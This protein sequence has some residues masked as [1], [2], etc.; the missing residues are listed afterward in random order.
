MFLEES[1][2]SL[3]AGDLVAGIG[4]IVID[5][6]E[7]DMTRYLASLD[8][9]AAL[10]PT[11]LFPAHGPTILEA[12]AKLAEYSRHRAWREERIAAAWGEGV[13]DT[14]ALLDRVYDDIEPIARPLA[15]RQLAAHLDRLRELGRID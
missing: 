8:R 10:S 6:P 5:P 13:R 2:G 14:E 9:A 12:G 7:G 15:A 4:T 3:L 1:G 11:T